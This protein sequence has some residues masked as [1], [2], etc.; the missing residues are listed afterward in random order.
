MIRSYWKGANRVYHH[1]A[2]INMHYGLYQ[3]LERDSR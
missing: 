2:P 3:A 1:T